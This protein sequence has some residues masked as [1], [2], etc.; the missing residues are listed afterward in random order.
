[1]L[2]KVFWTTLSG[3]AG[4]RISLFLPLLVVVYFLLG[5][6]LENFLER[7]LKVRPKI[8]AWIVVVVALAAAWRLTCWIAPAVEYALEFAAEWI[9]DCLA[10]LNG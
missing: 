2:W 1:M 3:M 5:T 8:T 9:V 10:R 7:N 4:I 6:P